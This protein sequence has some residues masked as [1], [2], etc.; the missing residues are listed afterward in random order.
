MK[1]RR[2]LLNKK[3]TRNPILN[4]KRW[5]KL[6]GTGLS[7]PMTQKGSLQKT[8]ILFLLMV[9]SAFV[10]AYYLTNGVIELTGTALILL[11]IVLFGI[12]VLTCVSP[13]ISPVLAPIYAILE[14]LLLGSVILHSNYV[15]EAFVIT[16]AIFFTLLL[17]YRTRIIRVSNGFIKLTVGLTLGIAVFYLI[18]MMLILLGVTDGSL[19]WG[20]GMIGLLIAAFCLFVAA[21]NLLIDFRSIEDGANR[22]LPKYM[23]W[24]FG[25]SLMISIVWVYVEVIRLLSNFSRS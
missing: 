19:I 1:G 22:Y 6:D 12:V 5:K 24:F 13:H 4:N 9:A 25:M 21:S 14:G 18:E 15:L 17:L 20:N 3:E 11:A 8:L 23:E 16:A 7:R 2:C 10:S